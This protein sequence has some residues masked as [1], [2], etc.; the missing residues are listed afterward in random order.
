ML[1]RTRT[2]RS[3]VALMEARLGARFAVR[4]ARAGAWLAGGGATAL[5]V[6]S[7]GTSDGV[8]IAV[9]RGAGAVAAY[10]GTAA[11][12]ALASTATSRDDAPAV[13]SLA[14]ARGFDARAVAGAEI[15][16][17]ARLLA[18]AVVA[19]TALVALA[20]VLS[21]GHALPRVLATALGSLA[22]GAATAAVL[23]A[24]VAIARSLGRQRGRR[25]LFGIVALP[26]IV[27][28]LLHGGR[29]A[30]LA[31]V[32]GWLAWLW[33]ALTRGGVA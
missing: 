31:S 13:A 27:G 29:G 18:R 22:F 32:P 24:L 28:S 14:R 10:G 9:A 5:V 3:L 6:A 12:L 26:W 4:A 30:E 15:A 17:I 23:A 19:P 33:A 21:A 16:A 20:G 2:A 8:A 11:A 1:D 7:R 25:W